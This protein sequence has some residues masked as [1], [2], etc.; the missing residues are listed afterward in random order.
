LSRI[1]AF[2]V[3]LTVLWLHTAKGEIAYV[4][5]L[6]SIQGAVDTL[7]SGDTIVIAPGTFT[8]SVFLSDYGLT[9]GSGWLLDADSSNIAA[10]VI[11]PNAA[12]PDHQSCFAFENIST[13]A[14]KLAGLTLRN[15]RGTHW[16]ETGGRAGGGVFV[17]NA[18][19]AVDHCIVQSCSSDVGG[20]IAAV[21]GSQ[22][23]ATE[24]NCASLAIRSCHSSTWGGGMYFIGSNVRVTECELD[25]NSSLLQGAGINATASEI[26]LS[27]STF[28]MNLGLT[29]GADINDCSGEVTGCTFRSNGA[30]DAF[31]ASGLTCSNSDML[32][33]ANQFM[34]GLEA[35]CVITLCC[36]AEA[37]VQFTGNVIA[38]QTG[39]DKPAILIAGVSG[40]LDHNIVSG[41][42]GFRQTIYGFQG[43]ELRIHHNVFSDNENDVSVFAAGPTFNGEI[44]SN[45]ISGSSGPCFNDAVEPFDSIDARHNWWGHASGPYDPVRN[46]NGQGD[47]LGWDRVIF[48]PWLTEPPDTGL[49]VANPPVPP[50][51]IGTW[52]LL[53]IYP[54]PFNNTMQLE[55][56]GFARGEFTVRLYDLLGRQAAELYSGRLES[57][58]ITVT[59]PAALASGVYFVRAAD[60][61]QSITRKVVLLK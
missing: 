30:N 35:E 52:Q 23:E 26:S 54:N 28:E 2:F 12:D 38:G 60:M 48:E 51:V 53:N 3:G 15:G 13:G 6:E 57:P 11:E 1:T 20:G 10:T 5:P 14:S 50:S 61:R 19:V 40:T 22:G 8:E 24:L 9:I 27:Q 21:R 36:F 34:P 32:I 18:R 58:V 42:A 25:S 4:S 46:P 7:Q 44:D 37:T 43:S 56:A 41:L 49:G 31:G 55:L 33:R 45:W 47:T 16:D 39:D 17:R 59:A 29:G